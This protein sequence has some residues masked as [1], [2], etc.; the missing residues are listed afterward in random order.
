MVTLPEPVSVDGHQFFMSA[1]ADQ[2][3]EIGKTVLKGD[4]IETVFAFLEALKSASIH[5][6]E[7]EIDRTM[8][9]WMSAV[10]SVG[11]RIYFDPTSDPTI[12]VARLEAVLRD[13]V[14]D[15][16]VLQYVDLR[17]EDHVYVK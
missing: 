11:Y 4:E 3:V 13:S 2:P 15:P 5:A 16:S 9:S 12:Q 8:G 17:F 14:P 6:D 1:L 7:L 10:T